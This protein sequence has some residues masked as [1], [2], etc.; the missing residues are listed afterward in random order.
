MDVLQANFKKHKD[1]LSILILNA[2]KE[3]RINRLEF[4]KDIWIK[5]K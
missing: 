2:E 3:Q 1:T 4:L 5:I